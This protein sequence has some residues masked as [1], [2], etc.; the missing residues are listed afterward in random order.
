MGNVQRFQFTINPSENDYLVL[1]LN[2]HDFLKI[3]WNKYSNLPKTSILSKLLGDFSFSDLLLQIHPHHL[4]IE[5]HT[6]TWEKVCDR[7]YSFL[8]LVPID[9]SLQSIRAR[10][11]NSGGYACIK[12]VLGIASERF[13]D[14]NMSIESRREIYCTIRGNNPRRNNTRSCFRSRIKS[15]EMIENRTSL[16]YIE[17][18]CICSARGSYVVFL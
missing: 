5:I 10:C 2:R 12:C 7:K 15:S 4:I 8:L 9:I 13:Y 6:R 18:Q 17:S 11:R 14:Q 16:W 3:Y 1:F